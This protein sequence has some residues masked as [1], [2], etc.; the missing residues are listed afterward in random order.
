MA[1]SDI[2]RYGAAQDL[3]VA[4]VGGA[5]VS[6]AAFGSQTYAVRLCWPGSTSST[7]GVRVAVIDTGG[8]AV[9]STQGPLLP[10]SFIETVQVTRGQRISAISNDAGTPRLNIVELLK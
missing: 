9:S 3:A 5:A 7:A 8:A 6:T 1:Y 10:P 4:S 2:Y